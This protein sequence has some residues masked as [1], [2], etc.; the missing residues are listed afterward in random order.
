MTAFLISL[1][2]DREDLRAARMPPAAGLM[3]Q[4]SAE[5]D[6][7]LFGYERLFVFTQM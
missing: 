4:V 1:P 3:H 5:D 7:I 2:L 6:T